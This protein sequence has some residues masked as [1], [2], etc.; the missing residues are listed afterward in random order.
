MYLSST[1]GSTIMTHRM[2][3][4]IE[5]RLAACVAAA[6]FA[7]ALAAQ[8]PASQAP[9]AQA[10]AAQPQP[11][12]DWQT[13]SYSTDGFSATFPAQ[14]ELSKRNIDTSAGPIELRSYV[15]SAGQD[16]LFV[17]VAD[18]GSKTAGQDPN[19][20]LQGAKNGAL[21]NSKSHLLR[22]TPIML[23]VYHGLEFEAESDAAH[24]YARIYMVGSTLYQTLVVT[25]VGSPYADTTRFLDSFQ[26]IARTAQ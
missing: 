5:C 23:G 22:E 18:Y 14:P 17:G 19:T 10:P 15:V 21:T 4:T 8:T 3:R 13:Y 24:F 6:C 26:L 7:A 25:P 16:A 11:A 1:E 20:L 2:R 12:P 9:P